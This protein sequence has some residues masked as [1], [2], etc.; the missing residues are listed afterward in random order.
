MEVAFKL[1]EITAMQFACI[2][3]LNEMKEKIL[4][5]R[6]DRGRNRRAATLQNAFDVIADID[7]EIV[8]RKYWAMHPSEV[9][10]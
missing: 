1:S 4:A 2:K 5:N 8:Q 6:K 9:Q 3:Q 7:A 10:V